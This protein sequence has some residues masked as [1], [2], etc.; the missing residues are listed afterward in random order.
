MCVW[1]FVGTCMCSCVSAC[2]RNVRAWALGCM[3]EH[4][5]C[6]CMSSRVYVCI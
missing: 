5:Q 4:V 6:V 2:M 3:F 1:V